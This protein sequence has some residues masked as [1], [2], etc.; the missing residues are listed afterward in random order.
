MSI[1]I[2]WGSCW[3][4]RSTVGSEILHFPNDFLGG[5]DAAG[6]WHGPHL[7][8]NN[9]IFIIGVY[10]PVPFLCLTHWEIRACRNRNWNTKKFRWAGISMDLPFW[11]GRESLSNILLCHIGQNW[12]TGPDLSCK[13]GWKRQYVVSRHFAG[14]RLCHKEEEGRERLL[15]SPPI[16]CVQGA[17]MHTPRTQLSKKET[18]LETAL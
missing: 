10:F 16:G 14:G 12:V 11:A 17:S 2:T 13:G 15:V 4:C 7:E 6:P 18:T 1:G 8:E 9:G 3:F 5:A